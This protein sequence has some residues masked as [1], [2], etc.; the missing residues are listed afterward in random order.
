MLPI[1]NYYITLVRCRVCHR[2]YSKGVARGFQAFHWAHTAGLMPWFHVQFIAC[3]ALQFLCNNRRLS[4]AMEN[5]QAAEMW[6]PWIFSVTLESMQL[7][8]KNCS[9]LRA[10]N[11]TWNRCIG[12]RAEEVQWRTVGQPKKSFDMYS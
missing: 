6:Q 9:A 8:S 3:N 12:L 1:A 5:F 11:C 2:K 10:R 4:N 7:L